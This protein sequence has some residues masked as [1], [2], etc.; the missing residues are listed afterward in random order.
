MLPPFSTSPTSTR[1]PI[2][3]PYLSPSIL[4]ASFYGW[5]ATRAM[6]H[7]PTGRSVAGPPNAPLPGLS[8]WRVFLW[9][10]K[11]MQLQHLCSVPWQYR[12]WDC[13][14]RWGGR[15]CCIHP[16]HW[17]VKPGPRCFSPSIAFHLWIDISVGRPCQWGQRNG[18]SWKE[19]GCTP[20]TIL[21]CLQL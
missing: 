4:A 8:L 12:N 16:I 17:W 5:T 7:L 20:F 9:A 21:I 2:S 3:S 6:F 11:G 13:N 1:E 10:S 14:K 15:R 19:S 18:R